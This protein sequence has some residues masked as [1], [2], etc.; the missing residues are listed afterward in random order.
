MQLT[1]YNNKSDKR[2]LN[3][4]LET[5]T[6]ADHANPVTISI[7]DN[8]SVAKPTFKMVDKDIYLTANYCYVDTLRRYYFID[9]IELSNGFAYL[10]CTV[11]VLMT[12]KEQ[13]KQRRVVVKRQE[14]NYNLYQVDD[15]ITLL[16]YECVKTISFPTDKG[17][18][19]SKQEFVLCT[20][21]N[22]NA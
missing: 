2:Y 21:G 12:Y 1:Y 10:H 7:L 4:T 6:L 19:A 14:N 8:C 5:I 20:I 11:D 3:K 17:F 16:N 9:D 18:D 13:L 15:K 22:T